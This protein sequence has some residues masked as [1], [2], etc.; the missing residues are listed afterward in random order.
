[1]YEKTRHKVQISLI[2]LTLFIAYFAGDPILW[3]MWSLAPTFLIFLYITDLM[4]LN[5]NGY[6]YEPDYY[7]WKDINEPDR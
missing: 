1:M 6:L 3:K 5:E 2:I 4:F 7:N